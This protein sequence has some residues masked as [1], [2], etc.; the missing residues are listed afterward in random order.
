MVSDMSGSR[1]EKAAP[2]GAAQ[3]QSAGLLT[4][5]ASY[6]LRNPATGAIG[7]ATIAVHHQP[8]SAQGNCHAQ[9]EETEAHAVS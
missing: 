1:N 6:A 7:F 5:G 8:E 3:C 2:E 9:C 4:G